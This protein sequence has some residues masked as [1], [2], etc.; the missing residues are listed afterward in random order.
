MRVAARWRDK[1]YYLLR[2][3]KSHRSCTRDQIYSEFVYCNLVRTE[4]KRSVQ[5]GLLCRIVLFYWADAQGQ[6]APLESEFVGNAIA[7][8]SMSVRATDYIGWYRQGRIMGVLLTTIRPGALGGECHR[9]RACLTDHLHDS[10]IP[11]D[12]YSL[13]IRVFEPGELGELTSAATLLR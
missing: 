3:V 11:T 8:L 5:S 1:L 7:K 2:L 4:W 9:V 13:H 10:L 6:I 12:G